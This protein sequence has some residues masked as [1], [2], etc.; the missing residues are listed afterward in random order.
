MST[1]QSTLLSDFAGKAPKDFAFIINR[2]SLSESSSLLN[3]LPIDSC[4]AVLAQLSPTTLDSIVVEI[5]DKFVECIEKG[6]LENARAILARLPQSKR[7]ELLAT[8]PATPRRRSLQRFMNYPTHSVGTLATSELIIVPQNIDTESALTLIRHSTPGNPVLLESTGG[9]YVGVMNARR[10]VE[11]GP[12][13]EFEKFSEYVKPLP[14]ESP[15]SEI[16][17]AEQWRN[18]TILPVVDHENRIL[19]V[20]D[21]EAVINA[22]GNT[23]PQAEKVQDLLETVLRLYLNVLAALLGTFTGKG[24]SA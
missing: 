6:P 11:G 5:F 9:Q 14:A 18:N 8:L 12:N 23:K 1:D 20:V 15:V 3:D 24:N 16:L 21:R 10:V 22:S 7:R 19:G 2:A 4:S 17:D 13:E